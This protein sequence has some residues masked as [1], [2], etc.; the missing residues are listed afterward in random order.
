MLDVA[1]VLCR[2]DDAGDSDWPAILVNHGHLR[3]RVWSQPTSLAALANARE[4][5]LQSVGKHDRRRH[6]FGSLVTGITEH[7]P[8]V[9]RALL[10]AFLA[11]GGARVHASCYIRRLLSNDVA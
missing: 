2:N 3:F 1:S 6:E 11:F 9:A 5:A 10:R 4:L 7:Q 8:L